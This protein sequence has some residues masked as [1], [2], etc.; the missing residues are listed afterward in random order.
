VPELA[1]I[2]VLPGVNAVELTGDHR[3]RVHFSPDKNPAEALAAE[4]VKRGW[5]LQELTPE[6]KSLEQIFVDLTTTDE[7]SALVPLQERA[8]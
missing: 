5:G 6:H 3:L 7:A 8:A 1:V 2:K 4:V